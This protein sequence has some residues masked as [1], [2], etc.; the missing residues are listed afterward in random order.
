MFIIENNNF[1]LDTNLLS[2][3]DIKKNTKIVNHTSLPS[4]IVI[5]EK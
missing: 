2:S 5:Y 3:I 1:T 4:K